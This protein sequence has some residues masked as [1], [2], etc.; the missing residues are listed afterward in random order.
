MARL[1]EKYVNELASKL[2]EKLGVTNK[3]LVP[4]L[5]KVV[6]N[7][8]FGIV[9]KDVQKNIIDDLTKLTGQ[10]PILCKARKSISNFK[11]REGMVIGAKVTLRGIRM[12]EFF[13]RLA[14]SALPRIRDFRGVPNRGFDGRGN[15]T[16]GLK[17]HTIFPEMVDTG[18]PAAD[19]GMDITFVTSARDNKAAKELLSIMGMPFAGK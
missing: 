3:M 4:C 9:E 18:N 7:M 11:L 14:N 13:D 2:Q 19:V 12:Y 15:Y 17:E 5:K 1:K 16:L 8:G 10:K 6:I